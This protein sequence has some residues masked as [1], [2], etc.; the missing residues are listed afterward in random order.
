MLGKCVYGRTVGQCVTLNILFI[1]KVNHV[2]KAVM[3]S[4]LNGMTLTKLT[5]WLQHQHHYSACIG[6]WP[7]LQFLL[8]FKL[9]PAVYF[10]QKHVDVLSPGLLIKLWISG[11]VLGELFVLNSFP[12]QSRHSFLFLS[13][14]P[15]HSLTLGECCCLIS[16][17]SL[18]LCN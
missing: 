18:V 2:L 16:V 12:M 4:Y 11:T 1:F 17:L 14:D 9:Q 8:S 10:H 3:P 5:W 13:T 6:T 7:G 15:S